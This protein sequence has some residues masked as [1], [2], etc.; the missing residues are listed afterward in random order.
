M[1]RVEQCV[2]TVVADSDFGSEHNQQLIRQQLGAESI[3]AAKRNKTAESS[4]AFEPQV[5]PWLLGIA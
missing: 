2:G 3:I 1:A 5:R 4:L